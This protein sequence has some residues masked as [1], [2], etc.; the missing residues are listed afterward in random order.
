[1]KL[2]K[3]LNPILVVIF[4]VILS[5]Q[6]YATLSYADHYRFNLS[7]SQTKALLQAKDG[8]YKVAV[9]S[10]V[11]NGKQRNVVFL[12]ETHVKDQVAKQVGKAVLKEFNFRGLEGA[13]TKATWGGPFFAWSVDVLYKLA[14]VITFGKRNQ[15]STIYDAYREAQLQKAAARIAGLIKEGKISQS[16]LAS[17]SVKIGEE[18]ISME[19]LISDFGLDGNKIPVTQVTN[20]ALEAGH[21]PDLAEN[22]QSIF[23]PVLLLSWAGGICSKALESAVPGNVVSGVLSNVSRP[24]FVVNTTQLFGSTILGRWFKDRGWY[25]YVFSVQFGLLT[26]RNRT[27]VE[28]IKAAFQANDDQSTLLVIVGRD[29]VEGMTDLLKSQMGFIEMPVTP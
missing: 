21:K 9:L 29:H 14:K 28:N 17:L 22:L 24:V 5:A 2:P 23:F 19:K 12:G 8:D 10:G 26:G 4:S 25:K 20:I 3:I 11:V 7:D 1:M 16:D 13:S 6:S 15:S 18:K 27:M